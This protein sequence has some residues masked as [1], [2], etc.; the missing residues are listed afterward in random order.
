VGGDFVAAEMRRDGNDYTVFDGIVVADDGHL[1]MRS[2][3]VDEMY[4]VQTF[5]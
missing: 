1:L 4:V 5:H 3:F 2:G